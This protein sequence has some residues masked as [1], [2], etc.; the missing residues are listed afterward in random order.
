M[1]PFQAA[2]VTACPEICKAV[3][4]WWHAVTLV[5]KKWFVKRNCLFII[6]KISLED[7][8]KMDARWNI[9]YSFYE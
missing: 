4:P 9:N 8:T 6:L 3:L 5:E 7:S 1:M 2:Q